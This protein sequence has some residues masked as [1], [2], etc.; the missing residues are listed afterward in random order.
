[1]QK[2]VVE[3]LIKGREIEKELELFFN[4]GAEELY[5]SIES[6]FKDFTH[7]VLALKENIDDK[8]LK[9]LRPELF[10]H[11]LNEFL[12]LSTESH[13]RKKLRQEKVLRLFLNLLVPL[14]RLAKSRGQVNDIEIFSHDR[15]PHSVEGSAL[16]AQKK[17]SGLNPAAV[18]P[19]YVVLDH[20]RS[21]FN[22]GSIFRTM[23]AVSGEKILCLGYT[24]SG[25]DPKVIK[26]SLGASPYVPSESIGHFDLLK[27]IYSLDH[28]FKVALETAE[29]ATPLFAFKPRFVKKPE[30]PPPITTPPP[31]A[32]E[33]DVAVN[34][35]SILGVEH[36]G[37]VK[38]LM[39]FLGNERLGLGPDMLGLMD[40][41]VHIPTYGVKNSLNVAVCF[42]VF[43]YH[44]RT[45]IPTH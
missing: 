19:L 39:V 42:G 31:T 17:A 40:E 35:R 16:L 36:K 21:S 11:F 30:P 24:P 6:D 25:D 3:A 9:L 22:V 37:L 33:R 20:L 8:S 45:L 15:T 43:A 41:V 44:L 4:E 5:L 34:G 27:E 18:L 28:F 12:N 7:L 29:P 13:L 10:T 23:D 38:P 1:M 32:S 2:T 26:S 14:E